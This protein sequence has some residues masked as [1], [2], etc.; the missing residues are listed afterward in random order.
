MKRRQAMHFLWTVAWAATGGLASFIALG[1]APYP[2]TLPPEAR[3]AAILGSSPQVAAAAAGVQAG[4]AARERRH[5]GPHEWSVRVTT[6]ERRDRFA[7]ESF[8]ETQAVLERSWR[9]PGK[10]SLDRELGDQAAAT[11]V[12]AHADAWHEAGRTLL[13]LWFEW[14]R[15][16]QT[17]AALDNQTAVLETHRTAVLR[18]V[19]AGD[20]PAIELRL[21]EAEL[22]RIAA[23]RLGAERELAAVRI[24]LLE[25]F[26]GLELIPAA[27]G[28]PAELSGSEAQW[29]ERILA[30]NHELELAES[31]LKEAEG[32]ADRA[33]LERLPDPAVGVHYGEERGGT[34]KTVGISVAVPFGGRGRRADHAAALA[35][36]AIARERLRQTRL[37][38]EGDA[39]RVL[40]G[41]RLSRA[42]WAQLAEL[43]IQSEATASVLRRGYEL[44]ETE[45]T[46]TLTAQRQSLESNLQ[47]RR[48]Q[49]D[50]LEA[51]ARLHLDAHEIWV[52]EHDHSAE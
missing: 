41:V 27:I 37:K 32:L 46:T 11:A 7:R 2:E 25:Q 47:A 12:F 33:R 29:R 30:D 40:D 24:T 31:E 22:N 3:I 8:P 43:A 28:V 51:Y 38:V 16:D 13:S 35:Q 39:T 50:A 17:L 26:P 6:Q 9:L 18:R 42:R 23:E 34:E 10:A 52:L 20:A 44:G 21:A 36:A 14:L 1:A 4:A 49:L 15:A 5:A 19:E 48:A 45:L